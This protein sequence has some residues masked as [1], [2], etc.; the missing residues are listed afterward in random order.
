M[1]KSRQHQPP[2]QTRTLE[3]CAIGKRRNY[4][5]LCYAFGI[6]LRNAFTQYRIHRKSHCRMLFYISLQLENRRTNHKNR[7][8]TNLD[9]SF[10]CHF[11]YCFYPYAYPNR[12]CTQM[13]R[14]LRRRAKCFWQT[15]YCHLYRYHNT[16]RCGQW[17]RMDI[18]KP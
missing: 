9:T 15:F 16:Y 10:L 12:G 3:R 2:L 4:F 1:A 5:R 18:F 17:N 11:A 13:D 6:H 14:W 7:Q 8:N